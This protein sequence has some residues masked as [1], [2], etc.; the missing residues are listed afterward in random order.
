MLCVRTLHC[1]WH[2]VSTNTDITVIG[3]CHFKQAEN[4]TGTACMIL[5]LIRCLIKEVSLL[6]DMCSINLN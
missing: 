4:N 5:D 1:A 2:T 6:L 3:G